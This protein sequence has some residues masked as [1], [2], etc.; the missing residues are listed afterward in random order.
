MSDND[1]MNIDEGSYII[2]FVGNSSHIFIF[3]YQEV[4]LSAVEVEVS[5]TPLVVRFPNS[6]T[7]RV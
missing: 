4:G 2:D 5:G 3:T 1:D 6:I 7:L